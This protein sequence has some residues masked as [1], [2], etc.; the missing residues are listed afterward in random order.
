MDDAQDDK[1]LL[2]PRRAWDEF[3][4]ETKARLRALDDEMSAALVE[5]RHLRRLERAHEV[6][7]IAELIRDHGVPV[8]GDPARD[9]LA[10]RIARVLFG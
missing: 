7:E 10:Q 3:D 8:A 2:F 1:P 6:L 9:D 4:G 5:K